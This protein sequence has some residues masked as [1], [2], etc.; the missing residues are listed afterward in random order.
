M[1]DAAEDNIEAISAI[2]G[3]FQEAVTAPAP[4]PQKEPRPRALVSACVA[5]VL[6]DGYTDL[7][8]LL[9]PVWQREFGFSFALTGLMKTLFSGAL[10]LFQIPAARLARRMGQ[11][12]VL[13]LGTLL[14]ALAVLGYGLAPS[15]AILFGLLLMGGI[16]AAVQHPLASN[17]VAS[18]YGSSRMALGTYNFFGDVGKVLIPS[19]AALMIWV[20]DWR[21]ATAVLGLMGIVC[22]AGLYWLIPP[23]EISARTAPENVAGLASKE[24]L[25]RGFASL[26]AI[27]IFDNAA[28]TGFLT[29]MPL[30]LS[31]KGA[32]P[33]L[34]GT[35]LSLIFIGGAAGKFACGALAE[36]L[37]V[38]RT[39]IATEALTA[40]LI[41]TLIAGPLDI[42]FIFL[43]PLGIAL[44]GTSSVLYGSVAELAPQSR[45][46]DAF[47]LFYTATLG[48][49]AIAP[50]LYGLVGDA[51]GLKIT[52]A[53]VA[54]LALLTV[55]FALRL[56]SHL[57]D[58]SSMESTRPE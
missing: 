30:L 34:I 48:A 27:G 44:N 10:S 32:S 50:P 28:R 4:L 43:I 56:G 15:P 3:R 22:A 49:G 52:L 54:L 12:A 9:L 7:L 16:G 13:S 35:A 31:Q 8:Y 20:A 33:A 17:V 26:T 21:T 39:V 29:F 23:G 5:H 18:A 25:K 14:I 57:P 41:V 42:L 37:G 11:A 2:D 24:A 40:I 53:G 46:A 58:S 36:R 19:A 51:A 38:I 6:H 1:P 45:R 55:P 47:A